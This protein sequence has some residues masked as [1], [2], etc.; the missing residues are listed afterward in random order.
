MVITYFMLFSKLEVGRVDPKLTVIFYV[1]VLD[2]FYNYVCSLD[3]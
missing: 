3:M 2:D 1:M